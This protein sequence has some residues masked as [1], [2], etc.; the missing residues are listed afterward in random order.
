MD[1]TYEYGENEEDY[2]Y[3]QMKDNRVRSHMHSQW[4]LPVSPVQ[5]IN[6]TDD[7][8]KD[9]TVSALRIHFLSILQGHVSLY[10]RH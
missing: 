1:N 10:S 9:V 6:M 2:R 7:T 4:Y 8:V 3:I 5:K